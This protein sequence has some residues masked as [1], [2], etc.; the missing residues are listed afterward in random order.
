V[1]FTVVKRAV[2]ERYMQR[3]EW[4]IEEHPHLRHIE[5]C[6]EAAQNNM[7]LSQW[8]IGLHSSKRLL[9]A[10]LH[11]LFNAT[12]VLLLKQLLH[13]HGVAP[14]TETAFAIG[15]F[16]EESKSGSNYAIDCCK[17]LQDLKALVDRSISRVAQRPSATSTQSFLATVTT[18][19]G[20]DN[21]SFP[22]VPPPTFQIS[23]G[24]AVYHELMTWMQNDNSQLHNSF[25]I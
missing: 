25:L 17:V 16:D 14:D 21:A 1:F 7:Q 20:S 4:S 8:V 24:D 10:G 5:A 13:G 11:F 3:D 6:S 2:A 22:V 23:E 9:Q 18:Q 19:D 15:V 12:I